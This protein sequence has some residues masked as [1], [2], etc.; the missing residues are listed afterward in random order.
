L[1][2]AFP[3]RGVTIDVI[4]QFLQLIEAHGYPSNLV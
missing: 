4:N 2:V 3:L 1:S